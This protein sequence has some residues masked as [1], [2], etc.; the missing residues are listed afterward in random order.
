MA[1]LLKKWMSTKKRLLRCLHNW[2]RA[3][4]LMRLSVRRNSKL[5]GCWLNCWIGTGGKTRPAIG[6]V[7]RLQ[8]LDDEDLLEERAGLAGLKFVHAI[9]SKRKNARGPLQL[10]ETRNRGSVRQGSLLQRR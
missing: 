9:A 3:F 6:K 1:H 4:R 10:C 5:A 2:S 8:D 7:I